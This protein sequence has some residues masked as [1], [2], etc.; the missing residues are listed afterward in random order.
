[1]LNELA[2][3]DEAEQAFQQALTIIEPLAAANPRPEYRAT[4]A[5]AT[6]SLGD[7]FRELG[8]SDAEAKLRLAIK[9]RKRL[10]EE[11]PEALEI[12]EQL[13]QS[14]VNLGALCYGN[15]RADDAGA[16]FEE[17]LEL[18]K[19]EP[20]QKLPVTSGQSLR[21]Q[22]VRGRA[23]NNLGIIHRQA[24]RLLE[25]ENAAREA[26]AIKEAL[27][28]TFP[29]VPQYRQELA[30]SFHNLGVLL[31]DLAQH[32]EAQTAYEKAVGIYERLVADSRAVPLYSVE[33]A[34]TYTSLG[35]L[36]GEQGHLEESVPF[37][38]KSIDILDAA[39]RKDS[40][41]VKVRES[42]VIA[43][44]ARA[45]TLAGLG[46]FAPAAD[47]WSRAIELNDSRYS[48]S[49]H[50]KRASTFLQLKDH[51]RATADAQT[52]AEGQESTVEDLYNAA[53]VY[54]VSAEMA[55]GDASVAESYA[56]RAVDL[57]RRAADKGYKDLAHMKK[58]SD[59]DVL[60]HREDFKNLMQELE[61]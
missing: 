6:S 39:Y 49:L 46:G 7:L 37:L 59:L 27:A 33:L 11:Q 61:E 32:K 42:L 45:M 5:Q 13:A 53:C 15:R 43:Y 20:V 54:A 36:I 17:V 25:A 22:Q 41:E 24:G 2:R 26:L 19:A 29:S 52:I 21:F 38:T 3:F 47:D 28:E 16:A 35:R 14:L 55:A 51:T 9:L 48:N 30:R 60:R 10:L 56:A 50:L 57:L 8:R 40:R 1:M 44:W 34:G 58:N 4:L 31:A 12:R 18:L 23:L